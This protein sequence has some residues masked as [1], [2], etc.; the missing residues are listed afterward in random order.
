MTGKFDENGAA[1]SAARKLIDRT[2]PNASKY[3]ARL[4]DYNND[5]TVT[6]EDVQKL[7]KTVQTDLEKKLATQPN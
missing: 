2:A 6:F 5:P 7:L 1:I 3:Q 4:V